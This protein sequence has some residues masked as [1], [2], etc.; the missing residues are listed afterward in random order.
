M[1]TVLI[2]D[3]LQAQLN[4]ISGYLKEEGFKVVTA[5][6]GSEALDKVTA[7]APDLIITDLVMPEMSGLEFCRKLKKNPDTAKIPV[8]ACTT[9]DRDMDKKWARKQGVVAY[10]VK[11]FSKEEMIFTVKNSVLG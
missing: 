3:D 8:I 2:V 10:L 7:Q 5:G 1:K 9:K 4:L 6:N 11:P